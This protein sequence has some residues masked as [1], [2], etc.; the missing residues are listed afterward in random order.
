MTSFLMGYP[1]FL[2]KYFKFLFVL[3]PS[4]LLKVKDRTF[5]RKYTLDSLVLSTSLGD[6]ENILE[7]QKCGEVLYIS[8]EKHIS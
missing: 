1:T 5:L 6:Q 4:L 7:I 2:S 3:V 8:R